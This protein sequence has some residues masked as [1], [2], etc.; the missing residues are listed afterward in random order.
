MSI[1]GRDRL[2]LRLPDLPLEGPPLRPWR[3]QGAT[4]ACFQM[5]AS[6][7]LRHSGLPVLHLQERVAL[8]ATQEPPQDRLDSRVQAHAQEG[9]H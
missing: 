4:H 3:Q 2:V 7:T 8:P 6:F 1:E 5:K 9:Y